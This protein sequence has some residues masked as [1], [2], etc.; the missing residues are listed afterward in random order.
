MQLCLETGAQ[1]LPKP[2][3]FTVLK[4]FQDISHSWFEFIHVQ[5]QVVLIDCIDGL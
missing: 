3:V 1:S 4:H 2:I 5:A